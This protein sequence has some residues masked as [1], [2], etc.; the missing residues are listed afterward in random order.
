[1]ASA[2]A[3]VVAIRSPSSS[4]LG[5]DYLGHKLAVSIQPLAVQ[6]SRIH[7]VASQQQD[8][9][10]SSTGRR[11]LL[12][13]IGLGVAGISSLVAQKARAAEEQ[14]GVASSRMSYSRFLEYLDMDRV[15]KV[16][17]FENGTVAIVEAVSPELGNRIQRVRV[18]LPGLNQELLQ[19]FREKNI[20]FAAHIPQEDLGST[21]V[22]LLGNLAF[23]LLLVGGLFLLSRRGGGG[24]PGGPG[25]P[26]AFGKSKA[27]FQMEPNTGVTFADVAGV[28]E[29][30]QDF[31]EVVEFLKKPERFTA[32]GARI[33]KG[34]LLVGP[35]G[36]GKTLLAK[37]IA[38]EAG[39]PFF[40][41][42]GSEFVEMF[43]GVGASRVR[44]LFKKAKENAPCI[45]FVDEIDA[46][47]RQ[48]G[49]GIG[50]GNDEREQTLNQLLT[51]MD[52]FEGNTGVIVIAA[53]NRSDIL[54]SALLRPGR[55][56]RQV[57]VDVPDVR[58]RTEILKVHGANKKFE[59]DV[60]LDIVAMRTP[61]FSGADLANLLNE[62]AILAGR[63]GRSA[64]SAKEVDDSIDRIVAGMEGTV[65]TDGK[66]KSLVAYH[67]VGHAVC[68]TLTQGHD[69]VQK[70]SLV[71]RGQARGLTWFIP[72]EDPTLI[73]KQ[74][75]F[76]RVVGA[77]GGRAAEEVI[78][79]EPEMTTG[80]AGDLQQVTQMARQM[81]TVFGMSEIGP[82]SLVD[83]SA[84]GGDVIMRMMARN[85]MS[86]KLAEDIDRS[87]KSIADKAYEIAL[88][89][90][91]K[92]R[93]AIDKIVEVL[94]EKET[95][96]GD[97]FRALLSEFTEIPALNKVPTAPEDAPLPV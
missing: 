80:A 16:D 3:S 26:L 17:L 34:V 83:P 93:A 40:S 65:M 58:G 20:D 35:P 71:P 25:N 77:L 91:R 85:S 30:K 75:I 49:T 57:T 90:V 15:K 62:A 97:E 10:G 36:T 19:K 43:V 13:K 54:D 2:T 7:V 94:L 60:K 87:V 46:V 78:F 41:I 39:V 68:A 48:R 8:S 4:A 44:D 88:G 6:S 66:V 18:Q 31:M 24:M 82:W 55:F 96:A 52:G 56:D 9:S 95:M 79:G 47:G 23:P 51:E 64:I 29:A 42:S 1:M 37:A 74:Q 67:E 5:K 22:N 76:A 73:S 21:V 27:K 86:E 84:Q 11:G 38:G 61:G 89:H 53:T 92:N 12:R 70:L 45:V 50:G 81:V 72:G 33:P 32:V 59:E 28:D 69:P 63:R 14:Q